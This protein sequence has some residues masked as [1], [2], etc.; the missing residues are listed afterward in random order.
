[1]SLFESSKF[2]HNKVSFNEETLQ[3]HKYWYRHDCV[4]EKIA[5]DFDHRRFLYRLQ[6]HLGNFAHNIDQRIILNHAMV[7]IMRQYTVVFMSTF[8]LQLNSMRMSTVALL[9]DSFC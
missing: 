9:I 3:I 2:L 4:L 1:M 7:N 5:I 6:S 8:S